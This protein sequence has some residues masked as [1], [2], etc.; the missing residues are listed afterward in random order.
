MSLLAKCRDKVGK[1]SI[2]GGKRKRTTMTTTMMLQQY[3]GFRR[4]F[5]DD[6]GFIL[7]IELCREDRLNA[8]NFDFWRYFPHCFPKALSLDSL[9]ERGPEAAQEVKALENVRVCVVTAQGRAFSAGLDITDPIMTSA[10]EASSEDNCVARAA[11][12]ARQ[13]VLVMQAA[14]SCMERCPLPVIAAVHGACIGAG[15]D[16][17]TAAD[18]RLCSTDAYF[19]VREIQLALAADVGTLQRLPKVAANESRVRQLC[20]TGDN[21]GAQEAKEL[22]LVSTVVNGSGQE[23]REEAFSLARR[24]AMQSP[25]ALVATKANLLYSRDHSVSDG[26]DYIATWNGAGLQS[27]DL[28]IAALAKKRKAAPVFSKL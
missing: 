18:I 16:L 24:I 1:N 6:D 21:F 26:L 20:F 8:L 23:V 14:L 19:S 22:G 2:K 11:L 27:T 4:Y 3:P 9:S 28:R 7:V 15:V 10:I 13:R 25:I 5:L 12:R 17:I